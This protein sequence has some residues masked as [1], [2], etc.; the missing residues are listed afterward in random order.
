RGGWLWD[1]S[2]RRP[3]LRVDGNSR[4]RPDGLHPQK[5]RRIRLP[6]YRRHLGAGDNADAAPKR[7]G[8]QRELWERRCGLRLSDHGREFPRYG[9]ALVEAGNEL[10]VGADG[11]NGFEGRVFRVTRDSTIFPSA[12][13]L[14]SEKST[15]SDR[16]GAKVVGTA[17]L[18]A[19]T[20]TNEDY[21]EGGVTLY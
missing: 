5:Q 13:K 12:T 14:G 11:A 3:R 2:R 17:S 4:I 21:G 20:A 15:A 10:W 9:V 19:I 18:I 8:K 16:F 7:Y 1:R 6:Q